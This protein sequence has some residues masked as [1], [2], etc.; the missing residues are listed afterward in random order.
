MSKNLDAEHG[1]DA[2]A[3]L[4]SAPFIRI[5]LAFLRPLAERDEAD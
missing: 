3:I 4:F 2:L 5:A 1:D